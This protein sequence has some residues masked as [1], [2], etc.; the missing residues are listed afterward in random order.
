MQK[1]QIRE[2][3]ESRHKSIPIFHYLKQIIHLLKDDATILIIC[4]NK[5]RIFTK[6]NFKRN[7]ILRKQW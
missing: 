4:T 7:S 1:I 2:S 5:M 3:E 6:I